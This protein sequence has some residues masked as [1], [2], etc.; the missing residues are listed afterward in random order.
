[1][2]EV[3]EIIAVGRLARPMTGAGGARCVPLSTHDISSGGVR[4]HPIDVAPAIKSPGVPIARRCL[5]HPDG[6]IP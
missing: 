2:F 6:P 3:R 5:A 1:L 4:H